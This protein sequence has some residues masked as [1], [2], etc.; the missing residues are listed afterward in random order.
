MHTEEN[1]TYDVAVVGC[2]LM[3]SALARTLTQQGHRVGAWNRTPEGAEALAGDGVRP[4][5]N[6]DELV[7]SASL[8]LACTATYDTTRAALEQATDW[9]ATTL[10]NVGTGTPDEAEAM[11]VWAR[12]RG[13][14]YLDGAILCYPQHIGT[15]DGVILF[16]GPAETW[17]AHESVLTG[18]GTASHVSSQ[19]RAASILD[20]T[21]A[22]GFFISS[23]GAYVEAA[24]YALSQGLTA[25]ELTDFSRSLWEV[26]HS[27][28]EEAARAIESGEYET[29]QATISVFAAGARVCRDVMRDAGHRA[30]FMQAAVDLLT[31]AEDAG[32]G[33]LGF[34]AQSTRTQNRQP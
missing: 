12:E 15:P 17:E 33:R 29:D 20:V 11:E 19:A 34:A 14:A 22:G 7:R 9:A 30:S 26:I 23:L 31:D 1:N 21:F 32:L 4:E 8:V 6:L 13:A 25:A 27:A 18:L 24:S 2:G 5:R 3:G 16:A 10:V 28:T